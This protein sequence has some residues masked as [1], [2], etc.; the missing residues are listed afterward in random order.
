M[1]QVDKAQPDLNSA[2]QGCAADHRKPPH[3]E[4]GEVVAPTGEQ[5]QVRHRDGRDNPEY[6]PQFP[7]CLDHVGR[8]QFAAS[9]QP[10][11]FQQW[12]RVMSEVPDQFTEQHDPDS[13]M[14]PL[15]ESDRDRVGH[16][17]ASWPKI[18]INC[19]LMHR[20]GHGTVR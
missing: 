19:A 8:P 10:F 17:R 7:R 20:E 4:D 13:R 9:G 16:V 1:R 6:E 3:A 5:A 15:G 18:T 11:G 14:L 12:H 2:T